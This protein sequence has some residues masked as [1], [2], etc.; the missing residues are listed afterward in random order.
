MRHALLAVISR[1]AGQRNDDGSFSTLEGGKG[2]VII[3][4]LALLAV[5]T[6]IECAAR[7][8]VAVIKRSVEWRADEG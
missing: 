2:P 8:L 6:G 3:G 4:A 5:I 7:S 1:R